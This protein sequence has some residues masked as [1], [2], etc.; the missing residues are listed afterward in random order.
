MSGSFHVTVRDRVGDCIYAEYTDFD[1]VAEI[2]RLQAKL[3][4]RAFES[5]KATHFADENKRLQENIKELEEHLDKVH[6]CKCRT[7]GKE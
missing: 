6:R 7:G 5:D 3:N 4:A 1:P 2:K